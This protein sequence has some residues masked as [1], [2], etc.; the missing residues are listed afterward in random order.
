MVASFSSIYQG[1]LQNGHPN[2]GLHPYSAGPP[3]PPGG[4]PVRQACE[5]DK[6]PGPGVR[7]RGHRD[8]RRRWDRGESLCDRRAHVSPCRRLRSP[9]PSSPPAPRARPSRPHADASGPELS[10]AMAQRP[11]PHHALTVEDLRAPA[12]SRDLDEG[13]V[14]R[15]P[16]RTSSRTP[17]APST[18]A[19]RCG[20]T[21]ACASAA[22]A[23]SVDMHEKHYFDHNSPDGRTPWDR[24]KAA[25]YARPGRGEHRPGIRRPRRRSWTAG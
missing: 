17:S 12:P 23:H 11:K 7:S 4:P 5:P 19:P 14:R 10:K 6:A 18:A 2:R 13:P 24:I 9:T 1:L 21:R 20:W 8:F 15:G 16:G 3:Q 22:R 25:G